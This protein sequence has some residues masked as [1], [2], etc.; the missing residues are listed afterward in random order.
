MQ[1][2]PEPRQQTDLTVRVWGMDAGGRPF[3][4]NAHARNI[5]SEG[6]LL[7]SLEHQLTAGDTIGVQLGSIKARF[8]VIWVI[9]AGHLQKIQAGV[10]ILSG[11]PCP[12][13]DQ[14]S[15]TA[16]GES[17]PSAT[18]AVTKPDPRNKS[19]FVRHRI[20]FPLEIR[21]ERGGS[22]HMQTSATDIGGRG[23]YVETLIPLPLGTQVRL[24]FWIGSEKVETTGIVR[25]SDGGVGMG[26]EFTG[27]DEAA[28]QRLQRYLESLDTTFSGVG[29]DPN[30]S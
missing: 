15:N 4:Q 24:V 12:W 1:D 22:A 5:S 3:F 23:C 26:I 10:Q 6:A 11:Q 8:R 13:K 17:A 18:E 14:L 21:D 28:Q 25:A 20:K 30:L 29:A 16:E 27:L 7:S 2:R 19:K 9:D